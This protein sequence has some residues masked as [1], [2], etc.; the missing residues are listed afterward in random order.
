MP[1]SGRRT[2]VD[3]DP[4]GEYLA[5]RTGVGVVQPDWSGVRVHGPDAVSFLQGLLSQDLVPGTAR[6]TFLLGPRGKLRA[7]AWAL[8]DTEE[9]LLVTE[10][11]SAGTLVGDLS[12]YRIRVKATVEP[13]GRP[14]RLLVGPDADGLVGEV[15]PDR[16]WVRVGT[17]QIGDVSLAGRRRRVVVGDLD[18]TGAVE[19][20]PIAATSLRIELGEPVM[21][22]DVDEGTIPQE[23]G[24]VG[25]AVDFDKGC[26]LGQELVARIDTR[27]HVNRRLVGIRFT[28]NVIPP[29]GATVGFGDAEVGTVTSVGESLDLRAPVGLAIVRREAVDGSTVVVTWEGGS[30]TGIVTG[31]PMTS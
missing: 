27:G 14:V 25:A 10:T 31:L 18:L 2:V 11:A 24:L 17:T 19:V 8:V 5:M 22:V 30:A 3:R 9:V 6:R 15:V 1:P 28:S 23:T 4:T 21:G 29:T 26:Y 20:G 7:I 13:D 12:R 16:G